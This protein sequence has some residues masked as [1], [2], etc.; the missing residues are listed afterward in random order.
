VDHTNV[1]THARFSNQASAVL[2]AVANL[3][4]KKVV[5]IEI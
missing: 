5:L 3:Y 2:E 4:L 1:G